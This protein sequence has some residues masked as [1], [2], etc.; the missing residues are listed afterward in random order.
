MLN[1]GKINIREGGF[2]VL[3]GGAIDNEGEI[4]ASLG[5]VA[6][7]SGD[8]VRLDI[9][10]DGL[11]SVV[12]DEGVADEVYD[13]Q[14]RPISEQIS[15][16]GEVIADG[17]VVVLRADSLPDIFEKAINLDGVVRANS[18]E[19]RGGVIE[20]VATGD[21]TSRGVIE[22]EG[23]N[24]ELEGEDIVSEGRLVGG[25]LRESG[26][27][28]KV[29]GEFRVGHAYIENEDGAINLG[30][31]NYSG[32][33]SDVGDVIVNAGAV[34]TL[35]GDTTFRAD[36]DTDG[37]GAFT[38]GGGSSV[39]GNGYN[40]TL[41]S[42]Q[43]S[44]L[45]QISGVGILT[46]NESQTGSNPVY[47][48]NASI[49][50]DEFILNSATFNSPPGQSFSV[51]TSF[52][53]LGGVFLRYTGSGT[54]ADPYVIYDVYGLQ[55]MKCDLSASYALV[56]DI[57]ASST[58]TWG[59]GAG[60]EPVGTPV[61]PFTGSFLGNTHTVDSLYINRPSTNYIGLFGYT[62]AVSIG[63]VGLTNVNVT[64]N[65]YV[66]AL[67]GYNDNNSS[68][69]NSY[70]T[71]DVSGSGY[72]GG[73]VGYNYSS[74]SI[75]NSY[76]GGSVTGNGNAVGGLV[77]M[78]YDSSSITNSYSTSNVSGVSFVGGL[79]GYNLNFSSITDCYS[80]GDVSGSGDYVGGLVGNISSSPITGSYA[81][82]SV[83]G[84]AYVGGLVG[85]GGVSTITDSYFTGDVSGSG[86][87]VGGLVGYGG[88]TFSNSYYNIDTVAIN[89][90]HK[91]TMG[92]IYNSQF[93]DWLANGKTLN[94]ADYFSSDGEYYLI[95]SVDDLKDMLGFYWQANKF[96]LTTD[97]DLVS[98]PN[99]WIPYF[100]ATEFD[101]A[102]H[103]VS[104]LTIDNV[105]NNN[106]IGFFG[107]ANNTSIKNIGLVNVDVTGYNSV[108]GLVGYNYSTTITDCY[109]TGNVNS[110]SGFSVGGLVGESNN[111]SITNSYST[112]DVS[113]SS[114][115]GGL[116]G[117]SYSSS[118]TGSYATGNVTGNTYVGGLVGDCVWSSTITDSYSTGDVSGSGNYVGGLVGFYSVGGVFT[119]SYYNID[120]VTINGEHKITMGGVYNNQFND[121]LANGKTLNP[122]DYFNFDG[123]Y[124]LIQSVDDL[125]DM[126]GFYWQANKFKLTTDLDLTS[127]PNL[128]IPYFSATE[129]DGGGH[130]ISNLTINNVSGN[131][132]I[133]FFGYTDNTSLKNIGLVNVDVAGNKYVGGLVGYNYS[134]SITNSYSTGSVTG[135]S[136]DVG[137]FVGCAYVSSITSSYSAGSVSGW[138]WYVGGLVGYSDGS[139]ITDS[140]F[141]GSVSNSGF[142][143]GGLIG[144]S[145][146]GSATNCYST[147]EVN[148]S[149]DVGGFIGDSNGTTI[150]NSYSTADVN[151]N[152]SVGGFIGENSS[153]ISYSYSTGHVSGINDVGGFIGENSSGSYTQCFFNTE[154]S[155][156]S[157]GV[158]NVG[159]DPA[160]VSGKTTAEM[161]QQ[162][163]FSGWDFSTEWKM[164]EGKTYPYKTWQNLV[165]GVVYTDRG[166]TSTV[167]GA[168]VVLV[169]N[170]NVYDKYATITGGEYYLL[171]GRFKSNDRVLV[172]VN[173]N[174]LKANALTLASGSDI[175]TFGIYGGTVAMK[176]SSGTGITNYDFS[177][178]RGSLTDNDIL[179]SVSGDD[180]T[181]AGEIFIQ[182]GSYRPEGDVTAGGVII[183]GT[184]FDAGVSSTVTVSGEWVNS[185]IFNHNNSTV[186][187]NGDEHLI[188]GSTTFYNL[189]KEGSGTIT[190]EHGS[191]QTIEG[192]L[193]LRGEGP[194][195]R[196]ILKSDLDGNVWNIDVKSNSYDLAYLDVRDSRSLG[197]I[198]KVQNGLFTNCNDW[199]QAITE[200]EINQSI[201]EV[202]NEGSIVSAVQNDELEG[203]ISIGRSDDKYI[204][205][206]T[207][208]VVGEEEQYG[209]DWWKVLRFINNEEEK[210]YKRW[211]RQGKYK[212]TVIV[213]EG[214]VVSSPYDEDGVK[215][216]KRAVLMPGDKV[217]QEGEVREY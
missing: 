97:L 173:D 98:Y 78:N 58:A 192:K 132:Y 102:G 51:T 139:G 156:T 212:T 74:S 214:K 217:E 146:G 31:G 128:W 54:G 81:T 43:D 63:D 4:V 107:Y 195:A 104:N 47:T 87:Y 101:G 94:P 131:N 19:D 45:E 93:N 194:G 117:Y 61:N 168:E 55:A 48:Q 8:A 211:Y 7:V 163:T 21:I 179:Y 91:I 183:D 5:K 137:G 89:G 122:A 118:I 177:I 198:L 130:T 174:T 59:G 207:G 49:S 16:S 159:S 60:F 13:V 103:T 32:E 86:N 96:K 1:E 141:V 88:I 53:L 113:A 110:S 76:S 142:D 109:T 12:I 46:I 138:G 100:A 92:G 56:G 144:N 38:M 200:S 36:S 27:S 176:D 64:G 188:T 196:L 57:D 150:T 90:E 71:G 6:L 126:L 153:T 66:G 25:Y 166:G 145:L 155:G 205:I 190:F 77:G 23:G 164:S 184:T 203:P 69:T 147:G 201:Q 157:D 108:G 52:S 30:T 50:V 124:Y 114:S 204:T 129:F 136:S 112:V 35:V 127:Y 75:T 14:G 37:V 68:I 135:N 33:T 189:T 82:G 72:V 152:N 191:T 2:G 185:G 84:D 73:L 140:Y 143:T 121:W 125:K 119:N 83:S 106:Y 154:S 216:S 85:S 167:E 111:S 11:I 160:G 209:F 134:S 22:A 149:T 180:L 158:G 24:I 79:V 123:E 80:T 39:V 193:T 161:R 17:G 18:V 162:A 9:S 202:D 65:T 197:G 187:L 181:A 99:L 41:Y 40:L 215:E 28:F 165:S 116:V 26:A 44:T 42:S 20:I 105:D 67:V 70:S 133:G 34:I 169:V 3:I 10:G 208:A 171:G 62:S 170:G 206:T 178:A 120:T 29:G 115:I 213:F 151:G 95:Q 199:T 210:K 175:D 148:G 15:N 182:E 186:V 172:Y